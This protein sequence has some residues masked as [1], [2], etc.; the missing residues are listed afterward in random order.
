MDRTVEGLL[1]WGTLGA[2]V[3]LSTSRHRHLGLIVA[4]SSLVVVALTHPRGTKGA[5]LA[6]PKS[7]GKTGWAL[8]KAAAGVGKAIHHA[9]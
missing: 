3:G 1:I 9:A 7:L 5:V 4:L 6:I 8:G 2:G